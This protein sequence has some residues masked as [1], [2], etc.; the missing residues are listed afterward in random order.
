MSD[1]TRRAPAAFE[2]TT[3][4]GAT[5]AHGEA[6]AVISDDDL[7]VGPVTVVF[8]DA[9][10]VRVADYRIEIDCWPSGQ[11]ILTQLGRRFDTF[12]AELRRS[13]DMARVAGLLAHGITLPD[14][15]DGAL[16]AKGTARAATCQVYQTHV[17]IVPADGDPWQLPLGALLAVERQEEPPAVVLAARNGERTTVG[18]LAR[19]RDEFHRAVTEQRN[20]QGEL[21]AAFTGSSAF[22]DG[23]GVE[24]G[25][26]SD[27][28]GM[29]Q[30]WSAPDRV[31]GAAALIDLARGAEP[32]LGLA[33]LLDPDADSMEAPAALPV[34]WASF[35][36]VPVGSVTVLEILAG[37]SAAT[38]VFDSPIDAV[39]QDL[40][41][42]HFRR[43]ALALQGSEAE[44]TP[45]NPA[46]LAL[47]KLEPLIRLRRAIRARIIHNAGW[48]EGVRAALMTKTA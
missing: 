33:Q 38:Y 14:V 22:A 17:T 42:L 36:L 11:L 19:R 7:R 32:R 45:Q 43:H 27:F 3:G 35:L 15:F 29:V 26:L 20:A 48:R 41:A 44:L 1:E 2:L 39:N 46:R 18:R 30:R 9:D 34:H 8:L 47:R 24:R 28:D 23:L 13:R 31:A 25:Q 12:A 6:E 16:L 5:T 21:L 40:Q 4:T 37:P 10:A